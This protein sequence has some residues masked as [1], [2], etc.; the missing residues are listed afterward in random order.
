MV[1]MFVS[2]LLLATFTSFGQT[3]N[4][5]EAMVLTYTTQVSMLNEDLP[6]SS[7]E[8]LNQKY[9]DSV[10]ICYDTRGNIR[11]DYFGS[12]ARG[13]EYNFYNSK[14]HLLYAKWKNL[15]TLYYYDANVNEYPLDSASREVI[16]KG[17]ALRYYSHHSTI[18]GVVLQEYHF[19]NDSLQVNAEL[20]KDFKDMLFA[21]LI[22]ESQSLPIKTII[23]SGDI[24]ITRELIGVIKM[25]NPK[26]S[27]FRRDKNLPIK[28]R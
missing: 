17:F 5:Q 4:S 23:A 3:K 2:A 8:Y 6:Q 7:K 15:D 16:K 28:E 24:Q 18:N 21:D 1:R 26:K 12:G 10:Q 14:N 19:L 9:G 22:E 27:F 20:Y 13:M 11:M 25:K